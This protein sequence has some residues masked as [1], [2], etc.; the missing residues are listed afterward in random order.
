MSR[1]VPFVPYVLHLAAV[2]MSDTAAAGW[3]RRR[4]SSSPPYPRN[5]ARLV[6]TVLIPRRLLSHLPSLSGVWLSACGCAQELRSW[7]RARVYACGCA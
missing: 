1:F 4:R 2:S 5:R 7:L 6:P 3:R